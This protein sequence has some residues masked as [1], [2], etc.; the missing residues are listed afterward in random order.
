M[1]LFCSLSLSLFL[2]A[3]FS[4][5]KTI[6]EEYRSF[7]GSN[8]KVIEAVLM[9]K[10]EGKVTLLLSNGTRTTFPTDKLSEADQE[11]VAS[12]NREKALFVRR[13]L[14]LSVRQLL[15]L[16]G[17]ES[18]KYE[19]RS[20]S[21]VI[22]GKMNDK[23]AKFLIDTGA[24]T[25]LLHI[26]SARENGCEVGPMTEKV[27]GVAGETDAAWTEVA[28]LTFG[29]SGFKDLKI[30]AA[31][32]E[33]DYTEA[34]KKISE[35]EDMLLG[36]ELLEQLDTVIDYKDRRI[37]FRPDLSDQKE[38]EDDKDLSFRLFK[39]K[40][41]KVLRGKITTK[42]SNV[43]TLKL[44]NGKTQQFP[45]SRFSS[46]D[47]QYIFNWSEEGAFF[48]QHCRSLTIEELLELRRYESFKYERKG[49]H[50]FVGGTLNEN[51]V[52]WMIDT[53]ADSSLLHLH[54]AKEYGCEI[55]PMDK[56]IR[57]VGGKAPAA[58]TKIDN[59]TLGDAELTNRFLL[60]TDLA[61][62][63]ADD[64]LEYVGLFGSDYMRELDAVITYR[65]NRIF[66]KPTK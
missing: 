45:V 9:D 62:F 41:G 22:P 2:G 51:D 18:F 43:V 3:A 55:G 34:E 38:V 37:F 5:G 36:A 32:M 31:D 39:L 14:G 25:S 26:D 46:E 64:S 15:E 61:R 17:Y 28:S 8:G 30:L 35:S 4:S 13:C 53:G 52:T 19:L 66:L 7:T 65:E 40:D 59:I 6:D 42:N 47:A 27:Y 58:A 48:L 49:N 54:W 1:K 12:W 11:Y 23:D 33:E 63:Q 10:A 60:S 24:G 56:E 50:I 29:Q 44:V 21:I 57:G 16:R 20:N